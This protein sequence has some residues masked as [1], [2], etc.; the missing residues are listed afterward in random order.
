M[1]GSY[2]LSVALLKSTVSDPRPLPI[3]SP[4]PR[5]S[6]RER[7]QLPTLSQEH[8]NTLSWHSDCALRG[9]AQAKDRLGRFP[10]LELA[11][12]QTQP[13]QRAGRCWDRTSPLR[14]P[15]SAHI[16]SR[17]SPPMFSTYRHADTRTH[18]HTCAHC[19]VLTH[20]YIHP[21]THICLLPTAHACVLAPTAPHTQPH[22]RVLRLCPPHSQAATRSSQ[23]VAPCRRTH[24]HTQWALMDLHG[25][26][27]AHSSIPKRCSHP[28]TWEF[29][30]NEAIT[31]QTLN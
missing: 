9:D 21:P 26:W 12:G 19:S 15:G 30:S 2:L 18:T 27:C 17:S 7:S 10:S 6:L 16:H 28:F 25:Y 13:G 8:T 14:P 1:S 29:C 20:D 4:G 23:P 31:F 5:D 22:Q 3:V 11:H 24:F